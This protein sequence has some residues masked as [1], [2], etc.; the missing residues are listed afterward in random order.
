MALAVTFTADLS[1]FNLG[2]AGKGIIAAVRRQLKQEISWVIQNAKKNHRYGRPYSKGYHPTHMLEKS[3]VMTDNTPPLVAEAHLDTGIAHYG[4]YVHEGHHSWK[5][6]QFLYK[7]LEFESKFTQHNLE[8][9]IEDAIR[10][11]NYG[12]L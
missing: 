12:F 6:D 11:A 5:P 2:N 10:K 7:A 9:A 4:P 1:K 3:V 8:M